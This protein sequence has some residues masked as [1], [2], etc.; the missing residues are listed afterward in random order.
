MITYCV[1]QGTNGDYIKI[2]Q[3]SLVEKMRIFKP[4]LIIIS[5]GFDLKAND[6]LGSCSVSA[7][8][9]S[10]LTKI[11]MD[12]ADEHYNGRIVSLLEGG[13][14]DRG[15]N[16]QTYYGLSQCAENH[17]RTLMTG[18]IQN[19]TEFF[20]SSSIKPKESKKSILPDNFTRS[21]K[22]AYVYDM[23]GKLLCPSGSKASF[24]PGI[25][26]KIEESL[27]NHTSLRTTLAEK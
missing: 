22:P 7:K 1:N 23:R 11:L 20:V 21:F 18:E 12:I 8:G 26:L 16:P 24:P 3:D 2:F 17:V 13:Y 19:E 15:S 9:I 4:D 27:K 5:C 14:F 25:Y 6:G 10:Q